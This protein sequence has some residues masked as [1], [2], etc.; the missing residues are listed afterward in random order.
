MYIV[1]E[2]SN[3]CFVGGGFCDFKLHQKDYVPAQECLDRAQLGSMCCLLLCS[4]TWWT[5]V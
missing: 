3:N 1:N 5:S 2:D 4:L